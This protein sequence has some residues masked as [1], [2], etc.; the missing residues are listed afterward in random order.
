MGSEVS[1]N[2]AQQAVTNLAD[3]VS[4]IYSTIA[5]DTREEKIQIL[6][7]VTNAEPVGD[8][9]GETIAL[10]HVIAQ[11]TQVE[12]ANT[13]EMRDAVR[14]I[15]I[16]DD[17]KAFAAVSDGM[18]MAL[19]NIF[20]IMGNPNTWAEPLPITVVEVKG[21]KGFKFFTVRIASPE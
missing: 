12:D 15:I 7:A 10:R 4:S 9:L 13:G 14:T 8:H 6:D 20:G 21:R 18:L 2:R 3:G 16:D 5:G 17:G 11:A 1:V 19:Q